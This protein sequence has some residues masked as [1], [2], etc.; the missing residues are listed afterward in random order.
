MIKTYGTKI[1]LTQD[2]DSGHR[3]CFLLGKRKRKLNRWDGQVIDYLYQLQMHMAENWSGHYQ[4][5]IRTEHSRHGQIFRGHPH[6]N[7]NGQWNDWALFDFGNSAWGPCEIWCFV[8]FSDLP[9]GFTT[10]FQRNKV[11]SGVFAVVEAST[12]VA[13]NDQNEDLKSDFMHVIKKQVTIE[14]LVTV[15]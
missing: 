3:S 2:P 14:Q 8:N 7:E 1:K 15:L 11:E 9:P 4:L 13:T 12:I 10:K 5:N 6:Y